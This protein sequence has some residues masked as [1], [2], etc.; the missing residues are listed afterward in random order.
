M[1]RSAVV[2]LPRL[3][4]I[5]AEVGEN[6]RLAR[7]RRHLTAELV[8]ERAS[9]SRATLWAVERGS[10]SVSIGTYL[11]VLNALRLEEDF[12]LLAKDDILGRKLQDIGLITPKRA[13][14]HKKGDENEP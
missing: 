6:I 4:R 9:I 1:G 3:Q 7:L 11:A 10:P 8:S 13:P 12:L 2:L 5:L 14:K